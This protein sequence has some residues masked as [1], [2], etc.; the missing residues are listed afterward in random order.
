MPVQEGVSVL[1][2]EHWEDNLGGKPVGPAAQDSAVPGK[3]A[4]RGF[5]SHTDSKP[6]WSSM[7]FFKFRKD[8]KLCEVIM[9]P[10]KPWGVSDE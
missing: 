5:E 10:I 7:R 3:T 1:M 9:C 2:S 8:G 4:R 6:K